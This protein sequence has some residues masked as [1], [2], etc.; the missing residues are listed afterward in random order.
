M[1]M[2]TSKICTTWIFIYIKVPPPRTKKATFLII[3]FYFKNPVSCL[4]VQSLVLFYCST[5]LIFDH[6][7]YQ[8]K[9]SESSDQI[10]FWDWHYSGP[11]LDNG[12]GVLT[13]PLTTSGPKFRKIQNHPGSSWILVVAVLL[14]IKYE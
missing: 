14:L 8:T 1:I 11:T 2:Q 4:P 3:L 12:F 6:N 13:I 10:R 9:T 5:S 7:V